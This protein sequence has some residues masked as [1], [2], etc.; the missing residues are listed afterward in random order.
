MIPWLIIAA[1]I[2]TGLLI[3]FKDDDETTS[4]YFH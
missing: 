2:I 4:G 3:C 1:C